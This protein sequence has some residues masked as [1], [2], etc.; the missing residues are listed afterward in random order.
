VGD[1]LAFLGL[2][3]LAL[4]GNWDTELA[5]LRILMADGPDALRA[6]E[7][8]YGAWLPVVTPSGAAIG[9]SPDRMTADLVLLADIVGGTGGSNAWAVAGI[10]TASGTPILANDPHLAPAI[11]APWYLAH[12]RTPDWE[13]AG[14]SFVGGP[15]F[16]SGHN[17]HA[18]WGVTAGAP[19]APTSSGRSSTTAHRPLAARRATSRWSG[20]ERRS[21]CGALRRWHTRS[22]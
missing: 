3:S 9:A 4:G 19:T 10:R 11:P 18:A 8:H 15:A 7:P 5:R 20:S 6:V 21:P 2:Q 13:V 1:V 17:G 12:L 14:A 22:S 16:P